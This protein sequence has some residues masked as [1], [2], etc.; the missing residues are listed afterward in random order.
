MASS[1]ARGEELLQQWLKFAQLQRD[2]DVVTVMESRFWQTTA[3]LMYAAGCPAED[4]IEHNRRVIAAI[5]DLRPVLVY[6]T[7]SD[8][9]A[10][11][12]RT[13]QIKNA[14]W[15]QDQRGISWEERIFGF[16]KPQKWF[17]NRSPHD[18][19]E[20]IPFFEAWSGLA[21]EL[22]NITTFPKIKIQNPSGDWNQT[23]RQIREFLGLSPV[24][25]D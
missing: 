16:F 20:M 5:R 11:M 17:A 8:V 4:V 21:E 15:Q 7:T 10:A 18:L 2:Q 24:N 9:R 6:F 3:M 12:E 14:E 19:S 1:A 23:M 22:Y 13:I 25:L